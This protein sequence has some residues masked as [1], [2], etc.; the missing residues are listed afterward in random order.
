MISL[1]RNKKI[2]S[3]NDRKIQAGMDWDNAIKSQLEDAD[4]ILLLVSV[5]FNNSD[6]IWNVE[7]ENAIERHNKKECV[8]IPIFARE[9]DFKDTPYAKIQGL[10]RDVKFIFNAPEKE[11]DKLCVEVANGIRSI[12]DN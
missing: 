6:Y 7:L 11:Q 9:C 10:P 8:V 3:W 1:K 5:D 12:I 4:I 2:E